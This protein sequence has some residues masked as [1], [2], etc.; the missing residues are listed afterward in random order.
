MKLSILKFTL[1]IC[2]LIST[3]SCGILKSWKIQKQGTLSQEEFMMEI[4]F[5]Y[6]SKN[7]VVEA[8]I[9]KKQYNFIFDT[10]A[11]WA[12]IDHRFMEEIQ[13]KIRFSSKVGDS[14]NQKEK[15][16]FFNLPPLKLGNLEVKELGSLA[17]DLSGINNI[18]GCKKTIHGILGS[19]LFRKAKWRIDYQNKKI[20]FSNDLSNLDMGKNPIPISM[21]CGKKG[22]GYISLKFNG[23][24]KKFTYDTGYNSNISAN[25]KLLNKLKSSDKDLEY[26]KSNTQ[27][28]SLHGI[29]SHISYNALIEKIEMG[30]QT[31]EY[32]IPSF[33]KN[34]SY[35]IG[36]EFWENFIVT[37][38]WSNCM[39]YLSQVQPFEPDTINAFEYGFIPDFS[40]S[41]INIVAQWISHP[42]SFE[43]VL[44]TKV[45]NINGKDLTILD[46]SNFCDFLNQEFHNFYKKEKLDLTIL[47]D[48]KEKTIQL[49]KAQLLPKQN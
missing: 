24:E 29:N 44:N 12:V 5:E 35:L 11:P 19:N 6:L 17:A 49:H 9:N 15:T 2:L 28:I 16:D 3:S 13:P 14:S 33:R 4:P 46:S 23:I 18:T 43:G 47:K 10:G 21:D 38:D 36:N 48:G 30:N 7:I 41:S 40:T 26:V 8:T 20:Q 42:T 27:T 22:S 34:G 39:I 25:I 37:T 1:F 31:F 45:L 32:L